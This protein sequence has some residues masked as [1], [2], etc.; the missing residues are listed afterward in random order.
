MI[1]FI[2]NM[3][4]C[5]KDAK[6]IKKMISKIEDFEKNIDSKLNLTLQEFEK[7]LQQMTFAYTSNLPDTK[8]E[9]LKRYLEVRM[10]CVQNQIRDLPEKLERLR[11]DVL[12]LEQWKASETDD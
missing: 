5:N 12:S 8:S 4:N 3:M 1:K 10:D 7:K 9:Y 6:K 11:H 2:K